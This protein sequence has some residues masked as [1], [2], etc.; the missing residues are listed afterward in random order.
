MAT[1][2]PLAFP[3][4][5]F[6]GII[7]DCDGTLVDSMPCHFEAWC[8]ALAQFGAANILKEDVFYAMGGR[9]STDI[10]AEINS[11]YDLH[12]DAEEVAIVKR[13]AFL[14]RLGRIEQIDEVVEFAR[15][16]SG[17]VPMA[18]ATGGSRL[19]IEKTLQCLGLSDL[20][21]E[22]VAV[23]DVPNGKPAPDVYLVAA[24]R[25]GVTPIHCLAVE[26]APAGI[27]AA[28]AAGMKVMRVPAP[29]SF[30]RA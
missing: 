5:G 22:V 15:K 21:D 8:D 27:L 14:R 7:F 4:S 13:A 6:S 16:W 18:V 9:P 28:Q 19:V 11:E 23:E 24:E 10:V 17:R 2:G 25:M 3:E 20:F 1:V 26:D 30:A 12:L 29:L